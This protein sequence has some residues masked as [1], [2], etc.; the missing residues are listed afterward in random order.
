MSSDDNIRFIIFGKDAHLSRRD[1]IGVAV[2][3]GVVFLFAICALCFLGRR[4]TLCGCVC[5]CKPRSSSATDGGNNTSSESSDC[6]SRD[7]ILND[8]ELGEANVGARTG[9]RFT[10]HFSKE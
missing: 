10:K 6:G 1:I 2:A 8:M 4:V 3:S 7:G 9:A 5:C